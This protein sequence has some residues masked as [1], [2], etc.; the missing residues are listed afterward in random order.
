MLDGGQYF[1]PTRIRPEPMNP[2]ISVRAGRTRAGIQPHLQTGPETKIEA[3][4][5]S[6]DCEHTTDG[7]QR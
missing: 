3:A 4:D 7:I 5:G 1:A 6:V 2:A